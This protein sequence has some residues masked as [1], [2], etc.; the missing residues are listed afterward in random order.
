MLSSMTDTEKT[1]YITNKLADLHP[2]TEWVYLKELRI[3]GGHAKESLQRLDAFALSYLPSR[4]NKA[5]VYEVKSS[6]SD[7]FSEIKKPIKRRKGLTFSNEFYFACPQGLVKIEE[8]PPEC[9][10]IEVTESGELITTIRAPFR[11][12]FPLP[13]N[14]IGSILRRLDKDRL[15]NYLQQMD[16]TEWMIETGN[17]ML[18]VLATHIE[19]WADFSQGSKEIPDKIAMAL[20][21]LRYDVL[22]EMIKKGVMR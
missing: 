19:K 20:R 17:I 12:T 13:R 2:P 8:I 4:Q 14:F 18:E 9:G 15:Y 5:V 1:Q 7:F 21:D 10:L 3:G 6:R 22:Q 11:D 16:E